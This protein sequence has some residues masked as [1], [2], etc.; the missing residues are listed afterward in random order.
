[1][2]V[3]ERSALERKYLPYRSHSIS[4]RLTDRELEGIHFVADEGLPP[5][6]V[7]IFF[8]HKYYSKIS[9]EVF[10]SYKFCQSVK[11]N[12]LFKESDIS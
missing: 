4:S 5:V 9:F 6:I 2:L 10:S 3:L 11:L 12:F 8:S 1:M 7:F